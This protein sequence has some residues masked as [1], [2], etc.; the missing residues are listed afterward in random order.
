MSFPHGLQL[1]PRLKA[2]IRA[3]GQPGH[4]FKVLDTYQVWRKFFAGTRDYRSATNA[5]TPA[6]KAGVIS[7]RYIFPKATT[8]PTGRPRAYYYLHADNLP[9][10]KRVLERCG[11]ATEWHDFEDLQTVD[12]D[13]DLSPLTVPHEL[14][15]SE[16][17]IAWD[18]A[19]ERTPG[20][21]LFW[22]WTSPRADITQTLIDAD[23]RIFH[24]N[25][26]AVLL[27]R[28]PWQFPLELGFLEADNDSKDARDYFAPKIRGYQLYFREGY[29]PQ[30]LSYYAR[31]LPQLR[32]R[33]LAVRGFRVFS[34]AGGDRPQQ[35][36][37][38]LFKATLPLKAYKMAWFAAKSD[39]SPQTILTGKV[40]LR[41]KEYALIAK[42]ATRLPQAMTRSAFKR[43]QAEQIATMPRVALA[44]PPLVKKRAEKQPQRQMELFA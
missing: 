12:T 38:D 11:R 26:D 22:D 43:W 17:L 9:A 40:W 2:L 5:L 42:A 36:R 31:Q 14:L 20:Y 3:L 25:P 19:C 37:D 16:T 39:L 44:S 27:L 23:G 29:L 18:E 41:G 7:R 24:V 21:E 32:D 34:V 6:V 15:I 1:T 28:T 30:L 35:R 8:D 4:R 33:L 10:I 13:H